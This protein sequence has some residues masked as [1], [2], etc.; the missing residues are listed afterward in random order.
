MARKSTGNQVGRQI[1]D[2]IDAELK[3]IQRR[4]AEN[5]YEG[6]GDNRKLLHREG[7]FV[8]SLLDRMR[9]YD[10]AL[11]LEQLKLKADDP[12]WGT[13]FGKDKGTARENG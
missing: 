9:V 4:H 6:E 5:V 13:G 2:S 8:Y 7:D 12:E 11:K 1:Q 3:E 10:R